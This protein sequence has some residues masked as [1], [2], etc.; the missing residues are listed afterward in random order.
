MSARW[1][2][3]ARH[4]SARVDPHRQCVGTRRHASFLSRDHRGRRAPVD[5]ASQVLRTP[6]LQA[7]L[8]LLPAILA[9]WT[10]AAVKPDT[11]SQTAAVVAAARSLGRHLPRAARLVSDPYGLRFLYPA[12]AQIFSPGT[13]PTALAV[14]WVPPLRRW[15][16]Y[17]QVRTRVIDDILCDFVDGGGRQVVILGA[18]YDCRAH[19]FAA[20]LEDSAVFEVDHPATQRR[21]RN[22]LDGEGEGGNLRYVT[23][24]F[25]SQPMSALPAAL[26]AAGHRP[27]LP[28]LTIWEGVTMYLTET[29][30]EDTL[31]AVRAYSVG[32]G[33]RL[34]F[35]YFDRSLL[36]D[37]HPIG[38]IAKT[39]VSQVGEP[40]R[41]GWDPDE[42]LGWM[43]RRSLRL[44]HNVSMSEEAARLLPPQWAADVREPDRRLALVG[45]ERIAVVGN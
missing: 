14:R 4:A 43:A 12:L 17:M 5:A 36:E 30:I 10:I 37:R 45:F 25:E 31:A 19:R 3:V 28:T 44:L 27:E 39:F 7:T 15:I 21:K 23:W 11:P 42:L 20:R 13:T 1:R 9:R 41:W 40:W 34:V 24:N 2:R 32:A 35:T 22:I 6:A 29:A 8:P 16:L 38:A 26:A 18:G 33:A